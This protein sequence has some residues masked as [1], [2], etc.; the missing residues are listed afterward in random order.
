MVDWSDIVWLIFGN[1]IVDTLL[2]VAIGILVT[3]K[4][5]VKFWKTWLMSKDADTYIDRVAGRAADQVAAK[6]ESRLTAFEERL[7]APVQL[8]LAPIV[9]M[10]TA[11]VVPRVTSEI[12]GIRAWLDGKIGWVR[13]VGKQ[14]GDV[15]AEAVGEGALEEAGIDPDGASMMGSMENMLNDSEWCKKHPGA[16]FGLRLLKKK[17]GEGEGGEGITLQG[18][19][20]SGKGLL[21]LRR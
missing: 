13:K 10:V 17:F 5:S 15:I 18:R 16:A 2:G 6:L 19:K 12:E 1:G 3:A 9:E 4:F 8:D 14:T 20:R 7:S 11:S 21:R